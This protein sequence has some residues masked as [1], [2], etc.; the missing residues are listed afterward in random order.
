MKTK[1]FTATFSPDPLSGE[2][3]F[4]FNVSSLDFGNN[5]LIKKIEA[6][7]FCEDDPNLS[8]LPSMLFLRLQSIDIRGI[9][10]TGSVFHYFMP[11]NTLL[12]K[13][14]ASV[15]VLL[16]NNNL[17]VRLAGKNKS[18]LS[19]DYSATFVFYY[20]TSNKMVQRLH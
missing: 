16:T 18:V 7:L 19:L 10:N 5:V 13:V 12:R 20:E 3:V 15:D 1:V 4:D 6:N 11:D 9:K 17:S 14:F 8:S 2:F